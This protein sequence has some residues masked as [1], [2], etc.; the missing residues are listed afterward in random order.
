LQERLQQLPREVRSGDHRYELC[1][2]P[3]RLKRAI[4][5][6]RQARVEDDTWPQ[7][8][9]LWPRHPIVDW[10]VDRVI[11]PFGRH[12][13]PVI[14]S[15]ALRPGEQAFVIMGL[16]PNRKGQ[17]LLVNWQVA[18][19]LPDQPFTLEPYGAFIQRAGLQVGRWPNPGGNLPVQDLQTA[20]PEAVACMRRHMV[21]RQAV[22]A[23]DIQ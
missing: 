14:Q 12:R 9:Y 17:P 4:E 19:Q 20:L 16:V 2:D 18:C 21:H 7:L 11:T 1:A 13:A 23:D 15:R 5:Q 10:L 6:A 22:F 8:H 3:A